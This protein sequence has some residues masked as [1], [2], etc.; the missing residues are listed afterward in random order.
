MKID[1]TIIVTSNAVTIILNLQILTHPS[2]LG[3]E[4][5]HEN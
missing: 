1:V 4:P 2:A 5:S 3:K